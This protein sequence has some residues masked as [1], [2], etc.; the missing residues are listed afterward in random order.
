MQH[1]GVIVRRSADAAIRHVIFDLDGTLVDSCAVCVDI[2]SDILI[3]RGSSRSIDPIGARSYMSRG[4]LDMVTGLLAEASCD[5]HV[6]LADFRARY[7]ARRTPVSTLFPGV[8]KGIQQLHAAG[9]TLSIC[10]NKPQGLCEKVLEDTG[11]ADYFT[12]VI[13]GQPGLRAKPAPDLLDAVLSRL[14]CAIDE[15]LFVGDSDLDHD[16]ASA[17]GMSFHFM[18]YGYAE[19]GWVPQHGLSFDCFS[20]MAGTI[21]AP[22][23]ASVMYLHA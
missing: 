23:P 21:L 15:C 11:L 18:T 8:A 9:L 16:V 1:R 20:T 7:Q 6:D 5:P 4:G 13:G 22:A 17:I 2:L 14:D 12:V 3:E 19:N 10:S